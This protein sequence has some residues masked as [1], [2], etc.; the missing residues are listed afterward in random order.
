MEREAACLHRR[1]FLGAGGLAAVDRAL[2]VK[3][4]SPVSSLFPLGAQI[5]PSGFTVGV[6]VVI[7]LAELAILGRVAVAVRRRRTAASSG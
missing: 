2:R 4:T 1:G 7:M 3:P 6:W 5:I